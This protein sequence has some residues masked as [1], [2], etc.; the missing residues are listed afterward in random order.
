MLK[1]VGDSVGQTLPISG[2][3]PATGVPPKQQPAGALIIYQTKS[4]FRLKNN[5]FKQRFGHRP[6]SGNAKMS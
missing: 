3:L 5:L 1:V 2:R 4:N 6:S